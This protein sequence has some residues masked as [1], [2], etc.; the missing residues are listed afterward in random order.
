MHIF[1][2]HTT[3]DSNNTSITKLT[4]LGLKPIFCVFEL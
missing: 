1:K 4:Y 3:F 2:Q